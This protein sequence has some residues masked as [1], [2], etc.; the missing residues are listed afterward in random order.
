MYMN[1]ETKEILN[2]WQHYTLTNDQGMK[3]SFLNFGGIITEVLVPDKN[4]V[5]ENVVLAFKDKADYENNDNYFGAITGPVAG[6]IAGA[7]FT[8]DDNTYTLEANDGPNHLHG[9]T[10]G[11]HQVLWN[12]EPFQTEDNAAA[13][14]SSTRPDRYSGYQ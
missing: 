8:I 1:I 14:L 4:G 11:F 3:V 6:R 9:R 2:Q 7:S 10:K 5:F 13:R 12:R